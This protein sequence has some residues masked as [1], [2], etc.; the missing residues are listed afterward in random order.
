MM[1]E[2]YHSNLKLPLLSVKESD[3]HTKKRNND[4]NIKEKVNCRFWKAAEEKLHQAYS[5]IS[6]CL[7]N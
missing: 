5:I 4:R 2:I 3:I 6:K 7:K 1:L